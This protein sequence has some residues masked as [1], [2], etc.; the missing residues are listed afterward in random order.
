MKYL[1]GFGHD[2][3]KL[4][5]GRKL[6]LGGL[7]IPS[8]KGA[9]GHSDADV[10]LHAIA[11]AIIGAAGLGDIGDQ[12]PD[13]DKRYKDVSSSFFIKEILKKIKAKKFSINNVDTTI[14][15]Q[16]PKLYDYKTKIKRNIS[17]ILKIKT[18]FINVK[19]KTNEGLSEI[20]K[21]KAIAAYAAVSLVKKF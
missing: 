17:E 12:F 7:E 10:V 3:H 19:A 20:G 9:K 11:D 16:E 14:I 4:I 21:G 5:K 15:C 1:I 6:F 13:T 18:D 8:K 2:I